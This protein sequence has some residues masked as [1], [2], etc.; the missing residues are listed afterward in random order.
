[1]FYVSIF[2]FSQRVININNTF[3]SD[4]VL[5]ISDTIPDF[6]AFRIKCTSTLNTDTSLVRVV[7][8][9]NYTNEYL[10]YEN[11]KIIDNEDFAD[12]DHYGEET[13]YLP[14]TNGDSV[15]IQII[16]ASISIDKFEYYTTP[17]NDYV[18]L[19]KL[20]LDSISSFKVSEIKNKIKDWQMLW[21]AGKTPYSYLTYEQKKILF[22]DKY[23]KEGFDFY[24][25]GFYIQMSQINNANKSTSALVDEFDWRKKHNANQPSSSYYDGDPDASWCYDGFGQGSWVYE[26]GNGWLTGSKNHLLF[27]NCPSGCYA[28]A[29]IATVEA[30]A[31]LYY[32]QHLDYDLSEQE[33]ISCGKELQNSGDCFGGGQPDRIAQY[34]VNFGISNESCFTWGDDTV[35]CSEKCTIPDYTLRISD[36]ESFSPF[37]ITSNTDKLRL[38][39]DL[40]NFGPHELAL[41][42]HSMCLTGFGQ[43]REGQIIHC[44]NGWDST[45]TVNSG[46]PLI[47]AN[48]WIIKNSSGPAFGDG[49]Y[50]YLV[51]NNATT[52]QTAIYWVF[53]ITTPFIGISDTIRYVDLD[54]DGY[55]NWGISSTKPAGCTSCPDDPDCND[56]DPFMGTMDS[57]YFCTCNCSLFTYSATP[58]QITQS[59][60]WTDYKYI[61][62]NIVITSGDTLTIGARIGLHRNSQII[63]QN[64]GVLILNDACVLYSPCDSTWSGIVVNG[65]GK[66]ITNNGSEI[67]LASNGKIFVDKDVN[68]NGIFYF[69]KGCSIELEHVL[70]CL[71]IKGNLVL[72]DSA[73]FTFTGSGYIKFSSTDATPANLTAGTNAKIELTG[74]GQSDIVLEIAQERLA[75]PIELYHLKIENAQVKMTHSST[76]IFQNF[77][78]GQPAARCSLTNVTFTN[79]LTVRSSYCGLSLY[80][81]SET[82][83]T[84]CT[85]EKG[86]CGIFTNLLQ[87]DTLMSISNCI[88]DNCYT[89]VQ[90]YGLGFNI[91]D[92]NF[93]NCNNGFYGS[94]T[95]VAGSLT[96]C[97]FSGNTSKSVYYN[98]GSGADLTLEGCTVNNSREI[99]ATG[100]FTT[101]VRCCSVYASSIVG[102]QIAYGNSL[103]MSE[104][105]PVSSGHN[106]LYNNKYPIRF[107]SAGTPHL[108]QGY[109]NL[110]KKNVSGAFDLYGDLNVLWQTYNASYNEWK[111]P[112]GAPVSGVDYSVTKTGSNP[113]QYF[114]FSDLYPST[115]TSCGGQQSSPSGTELLSQ[116]AQTGVLD[117]LGGSVSTSLSP[118]LTD[119]ENDMKSGNPI[120]ALNKLLDL[121]ETKIKKPSVHDETVF[122]IAFSDLN[123]AL[124]KVIE[125]KQLSHVQGMGVLS[126]VL[127]I[128]DNEIEKSSQNYHRLLHRT[129]DKAHTYRLFGRQDLAL[130]II[131]NILT[132]INPEEFDYI[133]GWYCVNKA[134][135]DYKAGLITLEEVDSL[136]QNCPCTIGSNM[137]YI[138]S[139]SNVENLEN[140]EMNIV[141]HK[142]SVIEVAPNPVTS[143]SIITTTVDEKAGKAEL[144]ILNAQG[145]TVKTYNVNAGVSKIEISNNDFSSGVYW[146][147]LYVNGVP[148][149][150]KK[151]IT[152]K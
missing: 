64:G 39:E 112:N 41:S 124:Y 70:T 119:A 88:F 20:H 150:T 75:L 101:N 121:M 45:I 134:E 126:R 86:A 92:C 24:S 6:Y 5:P 128:N 12:V 15:I 99:Y 22:G 148:E 120:Q 114:T 3:T 107:T 71:E 113:I 32:N 96:D 57:N 116:S 90:V 61:N 42:G 81:V 149:K 14:R 34:I 48:Y 102:L 50:L 109:N 46:N 131:E 80:D 63:V 74:S 25:G 77:V 123:T 37:S 8:K 18:N 58:L 47:G 127:A 67:I 26:Q 43:I 115:Y 62:S 66:I 51:D 30:V 130:N 9:N 110:I 118:S 65:G 7:L 151:I 85:F 84:G 55:Y 73:I 145:I 83:I 95:T 135:T 141:S 27:G 40:I 33:A 76:R 136:A 98:S 142:E 143:T 122:D 69:N 60:I 108:Y 44:K 72:G 111:T 23:N 28:F 11:I 133:K 2:S 137:R 68:G 93:L 125:N 82:H 103:N 104:T 21:F 13:Y 132:W 138:N 56:D 52:N 59:E 17:F 129:L 139:T 16:N 144:H 19:S 10:I 87:S 91:T 49:G 4:T 94:A 100:S 97:Y 146:L 152:I 89:G 140:V 106:Y 31:N 35:A 53:R 105:R 29:T 117:I 54:G 38:K 147:Q 79:N 78:S 1:M 36:Y